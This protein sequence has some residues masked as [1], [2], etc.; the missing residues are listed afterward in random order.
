MPRLDITQGLI[1]SVVQEMA[2][3]VE[4]LTGWDLQLP[5]LQT[6]VVPKDQGYEEIV[7]GRLQST[8]I[9]VDF[10]AQR[11]FLERIA[12]YMIEETV[13]GAYDPGRQTLLVVRENVDDSNLDG[14]RLVVAHELVHRGQ[15]INHP[16]VFNQADE[17][18]RG[19]CQ[20][21]LDDEQYRLQALEAM[22]RIQPLMSM[23][24]SHA[25]YVQNT[26]KRLYLP[27]AVIESHFNLAVLLMRILAAPKLAQ[28][29]DALPAITQASRRGN[30][31]VLYQQLLN[32]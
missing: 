6:R 1:Q 20:L 13:L 32:G 5:T 17:T 7:L 2:P 19:V 30:V 4:R 3:L 12:E 22:N 31:D 9:A 27:R 26:I 21:D 24:E 23:L 11:N 8:G 25:M 10:T 29:S 18:V 15:H 14:L 16:D 28:Y